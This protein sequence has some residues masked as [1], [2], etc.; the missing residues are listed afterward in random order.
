MLE[1]EFLKL[2]YHNNVET[3]TDEVNAEEYFN[4]NYKK[5]D[6]N[7]KK[8]SEDVNKLKEDLQQE[9]TE[10]ASNMPWNTIA[11]DSLHIEDSA[12]YSKNKL[13]ISGNLRQ[14]TSTAS[15]NILKLA[16]GTI[17]INGVTLTIDKDGTITINGTATNTTTICL[18]EE[19][20]S[21]YPSAKARIK[22]NKGLDY[23]CS[24]TEVSGTT[25]GGYS[26]VGKDITGIAYPTNSIIDVSSANKSQI[27]V[28]GT[29]FKD[30]WSSSLE[31]RGIAIYIN[32]DRVFTNYKI[33]LQL[34][35]N[36]EVTNWVEFVPNMPSTEFPSMPQTATGVQK[37]RQF[38]KN[39]YISLPTGNN[40][41]VTITRNKDGTYNLSGTATIN[42]NHI[43]FIDLDKSKIR[44]DVAYT[45]SFTKA[46]TGF[47]TRVEMYNDT[48][49]L[50]TLM[51]SANSTN[52]VCAGT[53]NTTDATKVRFGIFIP[54]GT[55]VNIQNLGLQL[56]E[57]TVATEY[58][59]Y[60]ETEYILNLGSTE[61]CKITDNNGNV[62]A[63]D[64]TVYRNS[65]WQW[66]KIIKKRIFNG[67]EN[68]VQTTAY[69]GFYRYSLGVD[70]S[71]LIYTSLVN[72]YGVNSHF[73]Q[74]INQKH[75]G[76]EYLYVQG[77]KQGR[78]Y[79][80]TNKRYRYCRKIK[81]IFSR[82]I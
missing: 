3:N 34:E 24:I 80:Y 60:N 68:W 81:N 33:R 38:G 51:S 52:N 46:L 40:G 27:F 20:L 77:H 5:I 76:Y 66:D 42:V 30:G 61:L 45:L 14:E 9:N 35:Q 28:A 16:V 72:V 4:N 17:T 39:L 63:Q 19:V 26:I 41:G 22:L 48:T 59:P 13:S 12:K 11:G 18:S 36:S 1:T 67:N 57:G 7:A 75:G 49:W 21:G 54:S 44:N 15:K 71:D 31:L 62:V 74:R 53:A 64:K 78:N 25:T 70:D 32:K 29:P 2:K 43:A 65:K 8:V 6:A 73:Q 79:I 82:A 37:I 55:T 69:E 23:A 10:L 50:R 56:E 58:E 47:S